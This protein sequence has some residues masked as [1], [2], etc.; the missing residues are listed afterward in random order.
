MSQG[1]FS[2]PI[3]I[4][5]KEDMLSSSVRERLSEGGVKDLLDIR[6]AEYMVRDRGAGIDDIVNLALS[7]L[8]AERKLVDALLSQN[9]LSSQEHLELLGEL[10][11]MP[12]V[13][14]VGSVI[15]EEMSKSLLR[16]EQAVEWH[17]LPYSRD[18][19]GR[20]LVAIDHVGIAHRE[21]IKKAL[22]RETIIFSLAERTELETWIKRIYD[23]GAALEETG[24]DE[25]NERSYIVREA[26]LDS[27]IIRMV[28]EIIDRA[29]GIGASD[30]HIEP[31]ELSTLIRFRIDG[32]LRVISEINISD[33]PRIVARVKTMAQMRVDEQR[34]PQDG[35][36]TTLAGAERLPLDLRVVTSPTIYGEQVTIRLLD[37]SQAMLSLEQLG[38]SQNNLQRYLSAIENPYGVCLVTGPTGSGKSTTLYSSLARVVRPEKKIISIEDPVEYRLKGITQID[39]S[40]GGNAPKK[41]DRLTF[42]KSLRAI[43]R[44]DPDVIM[45]GE[46]RDAETAS[47]AVDAALTGHFLYSTLHTNSAVGSIVRLSRIGVDRYLVA[48]AVEVI[49]AQR[50]IRTLCDCRVPAPLDQEM[51]RSL[52]LPPWAVENMQ[53]G[54]YNANPQGCPKC[55]GIGYLGRTG[56]HEVLLVS[57]DLRGEIIKG[58][59]AEDLEALARKEG[60]ISLRDDALQ[61][62]LQGQTSL[63]EMKRVTSG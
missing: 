10:Y 21:N 3:D 25:T 15:E 11:Q 13:H 24:S 44:S 9:L 19:L 38:M 46:I 2:I 20:L 31:G 26:A 40:A 22:S 37:P 56:V 32:V 4:E 36:A 16:P 54:I 35:R 8:N 52:D 18:D 6:V 1:P 62:V 41:T 7:E 47:I 27:R 33:T 63:E 14:L 30:I 50:L 55:S 59:S 51:L 53:G 61:K 58:S 12:I 29:K 23:P 28:D 60:M 39:V 42:A 45:V 34:L 5:S 48:E 49:V 43:L 57:D 17:A